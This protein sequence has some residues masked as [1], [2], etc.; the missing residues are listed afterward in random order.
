MTDEYGGRA[1]KSIESQCF[2]ICFNRKG[3]KL[4]NIYS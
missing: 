4:T 2:P 3:R 1:V